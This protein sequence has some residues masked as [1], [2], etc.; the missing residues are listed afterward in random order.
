MRQN[1]PDVNL[2]PVE[3]DGGNQSRLVSAD[4][5]NHK[6]PD[7]VGMRKG[8]SKLGKIPESYI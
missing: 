6:L 7:K 2:S 5:E 1:C 3:M 4:V 8:L